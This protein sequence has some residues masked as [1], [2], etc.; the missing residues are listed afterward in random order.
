MM[1]FIAQELLFCILLLFLATVAAAWLMEIKIQK[2]VR[3]YFFLYAVVCLAFFSYMHHFSPALGAFF[4]ASRC[5][6]LGLF[7][8]SVLT[9]I[10]QRMVYVLPI[11]VTIVLRNSLSACWNA[12]LGYAG[13]MALCWLWELFFKRRPMGEGDAYACAAAAAW[14]GLSGLAWSFWVASVFASVWG[15]IYIYVHRIAVRK[16]VLPFVPFLYAGLW[17][18]LAYGKTLQSMLYPFT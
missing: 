3:R 2:L 4:V 5:L 1:T 9:D 12:V 14:V 15:L 10:H 6:F 13:I 18:W 8:I 7:Y 16:L 11:I 17:V